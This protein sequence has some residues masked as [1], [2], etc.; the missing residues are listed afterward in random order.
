MERIIKFKVGN[1]Y[2]SILQS[3]PFILKQLD[4]ESKYPTAIALA[5][6]KGFTLPVAEESQNYWDGWIRLLK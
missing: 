2:T 5:K 3:D 1:T 6:E 4:R